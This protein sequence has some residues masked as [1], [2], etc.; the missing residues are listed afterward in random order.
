MTELYFRLGSMDGF[1]SYTTA[2]KKEGFD[3]PIRE[4]MQNSLDAADG[5]GCRVEIVID[6]IATDA[7]PH[8]DSYKKY[9]DLA[10][11]TQTKHGAFGNQQ[12]QVVNNLKSELKKERTRILMFVDNGCGMD[13]QGLDALIEQRSRKSEASG[14]SFGVGHLKPYDLSLLRYVM[15]GTRQDGV[16]QFTG[17]PILAG[18]Q[19][20]ND[21]RGNI[22]RIVEGKPARENNPVFEYPNRLPDFMQRVMGD[23]IQGTI[24]CILGLSDKWE[25]NCETVIASHFFSALHHGGLSV[26]IRRGRDNG[27]VTELNSDGVE[28]ILSKLRDGQRAK[29]SRGEILAGRHTWQ[30]FLAVRDSNLGIE[31]IEL[32][33]GD[34]VNVYTH[35]GDI[36]KSSVALI[37]SDM[38]VARHDTMLSPDFNEGAG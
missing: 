32:S 6:G 7:I 23:R 28:R 15:Y 27:S 1:T 19:D 35:T 30:S 38:L 9:L 22:G 31:Q 24:V 12:K 21:Q 34:R 10:I 29:T 36:E 20:G 17:V 16:T 33:S 18:F 37:R 13:R 14:G 2:D 11:N 4:L 8:L 25:D 3:I 26:R 5:N